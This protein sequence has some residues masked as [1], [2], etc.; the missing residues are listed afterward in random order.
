MTAK[1]AMGERGVSI[2]AAIF[3]LVIVGF[4]GTTLVSVMSTQSMTSAGELSSTQAL[5]IAEGGS[6]FAQRALAL[7]LTWYRSTAD[8]MVTPATT[9]GSGTFAVDT[10]L[11]ATLL[12][13]RVTPASANIPVYTTDRFPS[14]GFLQIGDITGAGEFVQYT[15][16]TANTFTGL[17]RDVA[18]GGISA[19][20]AGTFA[21]GTVVYPVTTLGT[22][23]GALGA[24]APTSVAAFDIVAHS[25][26]LPAG[27]ITIDTEDITYTGSST[28]GAVTTLTGVTR[29]M[30]G[31]STAHAVG[32]PVI[33]VLN[34]G[35]APDFE[36]LLSSTGA[37]GGAPLG[38]AARVV[39]KTVQR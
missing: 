14:S 30:N 5:Y 34:D 12:R 39:Q 25:K 33:P 11:P 3:F 8:P 21:R 6:E 22:P 19:G 2:L 4:L 15:G 10:F 16:V 1:R 20:A 29:C 36:V 9:L 27:T 24:C 26:L 31:V 18:I 38:T 13:R 28:A 17:T 37:V 35:T 32:D 23:L 7:N